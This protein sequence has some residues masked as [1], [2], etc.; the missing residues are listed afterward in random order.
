MDSNVIETAGLRRTFGKKGEIEA[1]AGVDL[2]VGAGSIFGF[3]G[4]NGAGKTTT[5]RMLSTLSCRPPA[6]RRSRATTSRR[7]RAGAPA[8]RLR[9]PER[10]HR[11]AHDRPAASW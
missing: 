3:L 11:P 5:L 10:R 2:K 7:S 4:P 9:R 6:R 8:H 1:V